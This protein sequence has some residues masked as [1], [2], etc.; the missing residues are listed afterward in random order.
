V[1]RPSGEIDCESQNYEWCNGARAKG[2]TSDLC[3]LEPKNYDKV[4]GRKDFF[5]KGDL[6]EP[7]RRFRKLSLE[8]R[9][10]KLSLDTEISR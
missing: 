7:S 1:T 6:P 8:V 10:G 4:Q 3:T 2:N 5:Q 9:I